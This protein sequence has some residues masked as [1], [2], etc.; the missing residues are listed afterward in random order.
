MPAVAD[1][2][3]L[4]R[5]EDARFNLAPEAKTA[6]VKFLTPGLVS[7]R[8]VK[9]G[10]IELLRKETIDEALP[11]LSGIPLTIDHVQISEANRAE[12][13]NG[14]IAEGSGRFNAEDG[15]YWCDTTVETEP[16]KSRLRCNQTP[17]IGYEVL[18]WGPGGV[19]QNMRYD[20]EIKKIRFNH[21]AIVQKPRYGDSEFRLNSISSSDPMK[22]PFTLIKQVVSKV[23]GVD[24]T[25]EQ[26][27]K[28]SGDATVVIDGQ[29]VRLNDL[30]QM[31]MDQ[32]KAAVTATAGANDEFEIDG[33]RVKM[34]ELADCYR[35]SRKNAADEEEKKKKED[36][37][38][39]PHE[40]AADE[41]EKKKKDAEA[42][43]ARTRTN[44]AGEAA[45][46][47]LKSAAERGTEKTTYSTSSGSIAEAVERGKS[48][49]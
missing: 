23:A 41:E 39:A 1:L 32:T 33:Q 6:S 43:A 49:Y 9:G 25:T 12:L 3:V 35:A 45:F 22:N 17:S 26:V 13:A 46:F 34:N 37:E 19:W 16:A 18:E 48:R 5:L 40:N 27:S 38:K 15:W 10:G 8:D 21:M 42:E 7:Y 2:P 36:E 28:V 29:E 31:W 4:A 20:R 44:K 47:E 11:T 14:A 30:G 24:T